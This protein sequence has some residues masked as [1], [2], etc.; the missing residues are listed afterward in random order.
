MQLWKIICSIG[1]LFLLS[2]VSEHSW[3]EVWKNKKINWRFSYDTSTL[4]DTESKTRIEYITWKI[5]FTVT[6]FPTYHDYF[7]PIRELHEKWNKN[8]KQIFNPSWL[9]STPWCYTQMIKWLILIWQVVNN[10]LI[11]EEFWYYV[12]IWLMRIIMIFLYWILLV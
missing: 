6:F 3:E 12:Y 5:R 10:S 11:I 2:T 7:H 4:N 8:L 9:T 1:V